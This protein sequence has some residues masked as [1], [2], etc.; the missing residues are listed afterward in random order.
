M[1]G[2]PTRERSGV[3]AL[4]IHQAMN[5]IRS[6]FGLDVCCAVSI[7]GMS[8]ELLV[9][10][11]AAFKPALPAPGR[12]TPECERTRRV[13]PRRGEDLHKALLMVATDVFHELDRRVAAHN[14]DIWSEDLP[15]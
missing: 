13:S 1:G 8:G 7:G 10:G 14:P 9:V 3:S 2:K 6:E 15:F 4:D 11:C 12:V 5:A